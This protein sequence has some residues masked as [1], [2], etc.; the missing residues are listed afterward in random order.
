MK[1]RGMTLIEFMIIVAIVGILMAIALPAY[2]GHRCK[3]EDKHTEACQKWLK[4]NENVR[5]PMDCLRINGKR[6]CETP[7][8]PNQ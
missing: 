1:I 3:G 4:R 5:S 7:E 6:Y 2:M 8:N